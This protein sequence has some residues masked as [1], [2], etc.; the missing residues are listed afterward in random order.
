MMISNNFV[1]NNC[2]GG[3]HIKTDSSGTKCAINNN[4]IS[5]NINRSES[6]LLQAP[7]GTTSPYALIAAWQRDGAKLPEPI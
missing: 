4:V 7:N 2:Q 1:H 6:I 5:S 3:I